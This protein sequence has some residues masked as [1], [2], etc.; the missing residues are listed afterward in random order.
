MPSQKAPA[1]QF[2]NTPKYKA[3]WHRR[4]VG[5]GTLRKKFS[6]AVLARRDRPPNIRARLSDADPCCV[7]VGVKSAG[8]LCCADFS[9]DPDV[10]F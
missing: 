7:D 8:M 5:E 2:E 3:F 10:V 9:V 1:P 4:H 6:P